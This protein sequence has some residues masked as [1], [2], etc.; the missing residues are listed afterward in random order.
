M[1]GDLAFVALAVVMPGALIL[2]LL[3]ALAMLVVALARADAAT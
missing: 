2:S 1:T 3:A